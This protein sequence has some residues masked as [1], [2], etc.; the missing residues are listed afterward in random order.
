MKKAKENKKEVSKTKLK[1]IKN[2]SVNSQINQL[3]SQII[4]KSVTI[5]LKPIIKAYNIFRETKHSPS[6]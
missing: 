6:A 4:P 5:K 2:S 3:K 1:K